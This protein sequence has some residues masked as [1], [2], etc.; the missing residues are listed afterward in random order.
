MLSTLLCV[1]LVTDPTVPVQSA[2]LSLRSGQTA[3]HPDQSAAEEPTSRTPSKSE[4]ASTIDTQPRRY[5][6]NMTDGTHPVGSLVYVQQPQADG[7][8][9]LTETWQFNVLSGFRSFRYTVVRRCVTAANGGLAGLD[10]YC[11]ELDVNS[12]KKRT[13]W[14]MQYHPR[15]RSLVLMRPDPLAFLPSRAQLKPKTITVPAGSVGA[16][17]AMLTRLTQPPRPGTKSKQSIVGAFVRTPEQLP[18]VKTFTTESRRA[19]TWGGFLMA[20]AKEGDT[21]TKTTDGFRLSVDRVAVFAPNG[22]L[23]EYRCINTSDGQFSYDL[24]SLDAPAARY[25]N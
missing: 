12:R 16:P 20:L 13:L 17:A 22:R 21:A 6:F 2:S 11:T 7:S 18:T 23:R 19:G 24:T 4:S 10:G 15:Q 9:H 3:D 1:L 5:R 14:K 8:T 25:R